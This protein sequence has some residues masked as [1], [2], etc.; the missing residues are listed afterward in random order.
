MLE[1]RKAVGYATSTYISMVTPFI[2]FCGN[3]YPNEATV[4]REMVGRWLESLGYSLNNQAAFI[5]C[6]RQYARF[7]NF[8]DR[9]A[10]VL[11][12][13]YS[14]R[15]TVYEPYPFIAQE[16]S[17]FFDSVD[18][19]IPQ[20]SGRKCQP[21]LVLP[22]LFRITYCCDMRLGGLSGSCAEM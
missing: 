5:A 2:N 11:G 21:K 8:L 20:M 7:I 12:D 22:P 3:I 17:L 19:C 4:T 10:F 15:R 6:L 9:K 13:A 1:Y 16:L 18:G 14:I